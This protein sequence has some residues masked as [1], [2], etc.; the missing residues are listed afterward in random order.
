MTEQQKVHDLIFPT[1]IWLKL[2]MSEKR[3]SDQSESDKSESDKSESDKSKSDKSESEK[4]SKI[5]I[6]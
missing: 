5:M 2:Q 6:I 4:R 3:Q 1:M